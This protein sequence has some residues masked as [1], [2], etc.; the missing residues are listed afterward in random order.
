MNRCDFILLLECWILFG[1]L[2]GI[3]TIFA[4][5]VANLFGFEI[6]HLFG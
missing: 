1:N 2:D 6:F 4:V 5:F 3:S